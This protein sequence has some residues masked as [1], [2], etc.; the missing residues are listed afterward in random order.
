MLNLEQ[1]QHAKAVV[2]AGVTGVTI[3][4]VFMGEVDWILRIILTIVGIL[5]GI[6]SFLYYRALYKAK[7][8]GS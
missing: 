2:S 7:K 6:Y 8:N 5:T 4:T 1:V 3:P